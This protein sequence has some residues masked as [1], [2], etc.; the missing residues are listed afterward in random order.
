MQF[1]IQV[2]QSIFALATIIPFVTF[3]ILRVVLNRLMEDK[4]RAKDIT[5]DVTT[6]L[7]IFSV[8]AMFNVIF[9]PGISG[10]W[11]LLLA[12]LIAFGLAG[13]AQTRQ[14]GQVD[15]AK[16]LRLIWRVGFL[17][18]SLLYVIFF[19]IGIGQSMFKV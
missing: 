4:K 14:Q 11:I 18:L 13:G 3:I 2:I 16:T 19:F 8:S 10:I 1:L 7:L 9:E 12:F 5:I 15:L 17:V 6:A